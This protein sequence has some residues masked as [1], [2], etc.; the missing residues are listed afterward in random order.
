M[1]TNTSKGPDV[2]AAEDPRDEAWGAAIDY[3]EECRSELATLRIARGEAMVQLS[4]MTDLIT[5]LN[6]Q[7]QMK[8]GQMLRV[9]EEQTEE[10]FGAELMMQHATTTLGA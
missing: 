9:F 1:G 6:A 8:Q 2:P 10:I 7:I 5:R 3:V 4:E